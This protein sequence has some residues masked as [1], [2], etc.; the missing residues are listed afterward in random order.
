MNVLKIPVM[1]KTNHDCNTYKGRYCGGKRCELFDARV[2]VG[3]VVGGM[4]GLA[5]IQKGLN[6]YSTRKITSELENARIEADD[7]G[8]H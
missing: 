7:L 2:I 5:L 8:I 6:K 4:A 3:G 1:C